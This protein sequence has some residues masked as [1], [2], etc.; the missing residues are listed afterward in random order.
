M[1][2]YHVYILKCSDNSYYTGITNNLERRL[3]EHTIGRSKKAYTYR[4]RPLSLVFYTSFRN[5]YQAISFEKQVKRWSRKKKEALIN[6][7]WDK[8]HELARCKNASSHEN[9][10]GFGSAQPE[11]DNTN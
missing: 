11:Y 4:R 9:Y 10:S 3:T 6:R 8:L 2:L 7:E 5:V 1:K